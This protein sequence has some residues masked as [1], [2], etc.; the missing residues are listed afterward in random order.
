[1][2]EKIE[3]VSRSVLWITLSIATIGISIGVLRI[4]S[5]VESVRKEMGNDLKKA[6]D[7][8]AELSKPKAPTRLKYED[9]D[10][11]QDGRVSGV[12]GYVIFTNISIKEGFVCI[13]GV[14]TRTKDGKTTRSIPS[15]VHVK[16]YDSNVRVNFEFHPEVES[17]CPGWAGCSW[18]TVEAD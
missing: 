8:I 14:A 2:F 13:R 15:C 16:A 7:T 5:E 3:R 9:M 11:T 18:D 1:M 6:S 12:H 17:M 4:K 10:K